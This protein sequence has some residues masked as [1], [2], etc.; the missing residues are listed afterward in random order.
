MM[1]IKRISIRKKLLA[2]MLLVVMLQGIL[3]FSALTF[4]GGF[5]YL[6]KSV[7]TSFS[8]TTL[9]RKNAVENL[10]FNKWSNLEEYQ[11]KVQ[12]AVSA[13]PVSYTHLR[14]EIKNP[15][16]IRVI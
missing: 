4:N 9:A 6:K 15:G 7:C 12:A 11:E 16:Q 10:M 3:C 2:V 1:N 8:N 14:I 5:E 13:K